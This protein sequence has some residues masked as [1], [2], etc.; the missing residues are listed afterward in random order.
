MSSFD[1]YKYISLF[2]YVFKQIGDGGKIHSS[3]LVVI[4]IVLLVLGFK[5]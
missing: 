4:N 3:C 1:V 2:C 5:L